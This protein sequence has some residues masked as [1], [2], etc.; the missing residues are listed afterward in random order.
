MMQIISVNIGRPRHVEWHGEEV[1]TSI[2][3]T[4]VAGLHQV[5]TLGIVGNEQADL[6]VHGGVKKAVYVYPSE[7][8]AYWREQ[9]PDTRF[10]WGAFGENLTTEG[11]TE[12]VVYIGDRLLI[13][14]A[15]FVVTQ[16]RMPCYKLGIRFDRLDM[17]KRFFKSGFSGLYLA[18]LTEGTIEAGNPITLVPGDRA[19]GTIAEM[20]RTK[21]Q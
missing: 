3:K 14:T 9:L 19:H 21:S 11:L 18:V 8:Y 1:A 10:D 20:F 13:G 5:Q 6:T 7:H 17:P 16:P 15:A 2:F 4:P 12:D